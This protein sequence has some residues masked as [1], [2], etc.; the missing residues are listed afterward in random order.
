[1]TGLKTTMNMGRGG[2]RDSPCLQGGTSE[3]MAEGVVLFV[4]APLLFSV[5]QWQW[6]DDRINTSP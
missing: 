5:V 2:L 3:E 6:H 4:D 1:M